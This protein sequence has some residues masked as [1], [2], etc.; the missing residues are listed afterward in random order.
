MSTTKRSK[1]TRIPLPKAQLPPCCRVFC[2]LYAKPLDSLQYRRVRIVE[3]IIQSFID[4]M[5]CLVQ[6][7]SRFAKGNATMSAKWELEALS[8]SGY[9]KNDQSSLSSL[10][11]VNECNPKRSGESLRLRVWQMYRAL[12]VA[13]SSHGRRLVETHRKRTRRCP[14]PPLDQCL[15]RHCRTGPLSW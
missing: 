13:I 1:M 3:K 12:S 6:F 14:C 4:F 9:L 10:S 15:D 7:Q 5:Q 2:I 11:A 8:R